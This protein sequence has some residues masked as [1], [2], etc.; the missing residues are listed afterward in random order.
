MDVLFLLV[1][2]L[3]CAAIAGLVMGCDALGVRK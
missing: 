2:T 3:M 1:A